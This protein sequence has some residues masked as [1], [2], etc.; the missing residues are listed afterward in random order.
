M[1]RNQRK[2]R[3][4]AGMDE[5]RRHLLLC[6]RSRLHLREESL[7]QGRDLKKQLT[8]HASPRMIKTA[9]NKG[10]EKEEYT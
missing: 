3:N 4:T 2:N 9:K 5:D 8:N 7:L 6:S 1:T 10:C